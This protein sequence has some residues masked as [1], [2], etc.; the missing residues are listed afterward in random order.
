[1]GVVGIKGNGASK[2]IYEKNAIS[3]SAEF[4]QNNVAPHGDTLR[5]TYTVPNTK[6]AEI[7]MIELFVFRRSAGSSIGNVE[8]KVDSSIRG[9]LATII[10]RDNTVGAVSSQNFG[11]S[12]L[13]ET[14]EIITISTEDDS[15]G[16]TLNYSINVGITEFDEF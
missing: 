6:L 7:Q 12:L 2:Q 5:A 1:M 11:K 13:L 15:T 8:I 14:G 4:T 10:F 9:R 3:E 16:G